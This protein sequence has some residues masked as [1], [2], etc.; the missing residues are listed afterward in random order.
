[1]KRY[2][3][4][5]V[6]TNDKIKKDCIVMSNNGNCVFYGEKSIFNLQCYGLDIINQLKDPK[7]AELMLFDKETNN[8]IAQ[9]SKGAKWLKEGDELTDHDVEFI[10]SL[11]I[12]IDFPGRFEI[13]T[14]IF[15]D[16]PM[17]DEISDWCQRYFMDFGGRSAK[18]DIEDIRLNEV[19]ILCDKCE[20]YH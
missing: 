4:K 10:Y 5:F 20:T 2:Y 17:H 1:M 12:T 13:E 7:V 3:V 8:Q 6:P 14:P 15:N 16:I 18:W 9:V 19:K 11:P